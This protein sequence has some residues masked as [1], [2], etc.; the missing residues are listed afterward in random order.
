MITQAQFKAS[1][2]ALG[3]SS[4][5][6]K[7]VAKVEGG[8]MGIQDNR[9][10]ILFEPHV[11]WMEL[12]R[13]GL[14]P[15]V[16]DLCYPIWRTKPYPK[17]QAAQW[18]RMERAIKINRP[19]ALASASWGMF[20]IMGFNY[21]KCGYKTIQE[22][23]NAMYE[24]EDKQLEIFCHYIIKV[25]LDDEL[26][27]FD[28]PKILSLAARQFAAGYNGKYYFKNNYHIKLKTAYLS[29]V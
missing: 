2:F 28:N 14:K 25:G 3:C 10:I 8:G 23:V 29:A 1:A 22:F 13:R 17:S 6:V 18:A 11:F 7:A 20:Q 12:K 24:S 27:A 4:R 21:A 15:V 26:R 16:S 5:A 9:P 19:A